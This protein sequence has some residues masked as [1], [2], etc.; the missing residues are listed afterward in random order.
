M[1]N[2]FDRTIIIIDI[3]I[4]LS[5]FSTPL[6][7]LYNLTLLQLKIHV[8]FSVLFLVRF[9]LKLLLFT[10]IVVSFIV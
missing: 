3:I 7:K 1:L 4:F 6:Y 2:I 5:I 9:V 8:I 10:P